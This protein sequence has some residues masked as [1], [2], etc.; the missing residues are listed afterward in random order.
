MLCYRL[1]EPA[2]GLYVGGVVAIVEVDDDLAVE[3]GRI[4]E[5]SGRVGLPNRLQ[6]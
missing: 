3:N 4:S 2:P 6:R 1:V 5:Y